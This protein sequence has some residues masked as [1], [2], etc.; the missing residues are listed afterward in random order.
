MRCSNFLI[1]GVVLPLFGLLANATGIELANNGGFETGD[2]TGWSQFE[3]TPGDQTITAINPSTGTYALKIDNQVMGS[4]S[5]IKQANLAAGQLLP[6]QAITVSFDARGEFGVGGVAFAQL[7]SEVDGGGVSK[8][9]FIDGGPLGVDPD[10]SVWTSFSLTTTLGP[11][12]SGGVTLQLEAPTAAIS[13]TFTTMWYDNISIT[14]DS[15]LPPPEIPEPSSLA[16][17]GISGLLVGLGRRR[18]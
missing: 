14:V 1:A 5:L 15:L 10:P 6:G 13:G 4:N 11:D 16:L 9:E 18:T 3:V 8:A 7:F 12:V 2:F 17:L